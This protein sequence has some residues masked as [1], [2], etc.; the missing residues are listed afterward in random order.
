MADARTINRSAVARAQLRRLA[1]APWGVNLTVLRDG[2][3]LL[4]FGGDFAGYTFSDEDFVL[5]GAVNELERF[6]AAEQKRM[7]KNAVNGDSLVMEFVNARTDEQLI[8]FVRRYGPVSGYPPAVE[9]PKGSDHEHLRFVER[10]GEISSGDIAIQNLEVL[11]IERSFAERIQLLTSAFWEAN[12]PTNELL[13]IQGSN[14]GSWYKKVKPVVRDIWHQLA[15]LNRILDRARAVP[16]FK[17][18]L[19]ISWGDQL[20]SCLSPFTYKLDDHANGEDV[21]HLNVYFIAESC[22]CSFF[23]SVRGNL[24]LNRGAVEEVPNVSEY[25]ILPVL[26]FMLRECFLAQRRVAICAKPGCGNSF[27]IDRS[28]AR[29]CS[30]TCAH[31]FAQREY[32]KRGG[33]QKRT[34][35][36]LQL[37]SKNPKPRKRLS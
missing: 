11:R 4:V 35:K 15:E 29:F 19:S 20:R 7:T 32:W 37:K 16:K 28:G 25:G 10:Q 1:P 13:A 22:L 12:E 18:P 31:A 6:R 36:R 21:E 5:A 33:K 26:H 8:E 2:E 34:E 17:R 9:Q 3:E 27:L 14:V 23:G 30:E 24:V